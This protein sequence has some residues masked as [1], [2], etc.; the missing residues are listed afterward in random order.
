MQGSEGRGSQKTIGW[1]TPAGQVIEGRRISEGLSP[2][3]IEDD[4]LRRQAAQYGYVSMEGRS[5]LPTGVMRL[6][7]VRATVACFGLFVVNAIVF[8]WLVATY[9]ERYYLVGAFD[10]FGL[11]GL[12]GLGTAVFLA[13]SALLLESRLR[14]RSKGGLLVQVRRWLLWTVLCVGGVLSVPLLWLVLVVSGIGHYTSL[15]VIGAHEYIVKETTFDESAL[16]LFV[17]NGLEIKRVSTSGLSLTNGTPFEDGDFTIDH[18]LNTV[19]VT[20]P[21]GTFTFVP[22]GPD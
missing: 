12:S 15:G 16:S 7:S 6:E 4:V 11:L 14:R 3:I 20:I 22:I 18:G 1:W 2:V 5:P 10:D 13:V 9:G 19:T 21:D 8:G 17:R